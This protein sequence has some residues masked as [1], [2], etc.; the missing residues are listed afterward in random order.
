MKQSCWFIRLETAGDAPDIEALQSDAFGP[1][2]FA[3]TA[4]R[5]REGVPHREDLSFVAWSGTA[6]AGSIRLTTVHIGETPSLLLG[7]LTVAPAFKNRGIGKK[8]MQ[9]ALEAA[10]RSGETTVLLVG[11]AAYYCPLGFQQ[12]PF[13]Q[14]AFPGPVDP[15]RILVAC[16]NG[17]P[18]PAGDVT[19]RR[20]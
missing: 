8:L 19:A 15:A 13:G 9:T 1:G 17:A 10:T 6:L 20:P 5:V 7:P 4:F 3:R 11:D 18:V 14:I 2:R 16:L 12:V